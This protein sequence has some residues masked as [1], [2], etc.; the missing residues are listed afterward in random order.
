MKNVFWCGYSVKIYLSRF[1]WGFGSQSC[2]DFTLNGSND[3]LFS[4]IGA[5]WGLS[6]KDWNLDVKNRNF[7][8]MNRHFHA[9]L[10]KYENFS[11]LEI[12]R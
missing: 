7:G 1:C 12:L 6:D 5:F 8:G 11:I 2:G 10:T 3:V 4:T 9:K